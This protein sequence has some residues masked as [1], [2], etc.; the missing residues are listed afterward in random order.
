M[1]VQSVDWTCSACSLAWVL[2]ATAQDTTA[3]EWSEVEAIGYPQNINPTYGLMDGS[4]Y[5]LQRVFRDNGL[6]SSQG[7]LTFDQVYAIAGSNTGMMSGGGWYHWVAIRG[8]DD[9]N[10]WIAN[11]A[12][13]YK[14]V[15]EI[16]TREDFNR[17]GP[18]SVVWVTEYL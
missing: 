12:P 4:G 6:D 11:S 3:D 2:R 10:L 1:P 15:W 8:R 17:L 7:W 9:T 18:F 13:G 14:G 5:Q 16:L